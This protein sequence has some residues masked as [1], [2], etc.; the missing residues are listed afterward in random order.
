[1]YKF[2]KWYFKLAQYFCAASRN[3]GCTF[4]HASPASCQVTSN[5]DGCPIRLPSSHWSY[6]DYE[7]ECID[8]RG[9]DI[10]NDNFFT[11]VTY[12]LDSRYVIISHFYTN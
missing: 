6:P 1:M 3:N 5:S 8:S 12:G 10:E 11:A 2:K 9:N 4:D 7:G